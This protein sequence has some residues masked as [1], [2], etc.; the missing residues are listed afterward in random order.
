MDLPASVDLNVSTLCVI[1]DGR[2][3]LCA[4]DN[5]RN[6]FLEIRRVDNEAVK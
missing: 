6:L 2:I 5:T 3:I 1:A 4:R